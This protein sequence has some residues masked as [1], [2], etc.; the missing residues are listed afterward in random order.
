MRYLDSA[1]LS[2]PR[3]HLR[4][5]WTA[6]IVFSSNAVCLGQETRTVGVTSD[7]ALVVTYSPDGKSIASAHLDKSIKIW[8]AGSGKKKTSLIGHRHIPR[9]L[10]FSP[11]GK[12][13]A[14]V[15]DGGMLMFW[16]V[17]TG[18]AT[19]EYVGNLEISTCVAFSSDAKLV[20]AGSIGIS[21]SGVISK[22]DLKWREFPTGKDLRSSQEDNGIRS[23]AFSPDGK[24]L[25]TAGR[26]LQWWDVETGHLKR[27]HKPDKGGIGSVSFS[28]DGK[29][30]AT[31][32]GHA[33][34][35]EGGGFRSKGN[36]QLWNAQTG[37]L[38]RT[39]ADDLKGVMQVRISPDGKFVAAGCEGPI[40][41]YDNGFSQKIV[42]VMNV[43][44]IGTGKL[45]WSTEG[46]SHRFES[47]C[48]SP[49]GKMIAGCDGEIIAIF[50]AKTGEKAQT[51]FT[52]TLGPILR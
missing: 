49:D 34:M 47:I 42:S 18:K 28:P 48:F 39:L 11:D 51:L 43:W 2:M 3:G 10:A 20:V 37:E 9:S 16:D 23:L 32:G 4:F 30:L 21:P 33:V 52:R 46:K 14:S 45:A 50:D 26:Y 8:D 41:I 13:L 7:N 27:T 29:L 25:A 38:Q 12:T 17:E 31:G 40:K 1:E 36:V 15:G 35:V 5:L 6:M 24:T 44:E 19:Q 22:G